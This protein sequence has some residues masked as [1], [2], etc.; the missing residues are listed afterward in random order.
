MYAA[1]TTDSLAEPFYIE[2][3]RRSALYESIQTAQMYE[4]PTS[5]INT[6]TSLDHHHTYHTLEAT[7]SSHHGNS[8]QYY[9]ES[10]NYQVLEPPSSNIGDMEEGHDY[11]ELE[12][13]RSSK[14]KSSY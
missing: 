3:T 9:S 13:L 5:S 14:V 8:T 10:E 12:A 2:A 6:E 4:V 1:P 7:R 11:H